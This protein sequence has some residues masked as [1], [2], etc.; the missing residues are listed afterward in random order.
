MESFKTFISESSDL[1]KSQVMVINA[2]K[3]DHDVE[4]EVL[5][6][7]GKFSLAYV[8]VKIKKD[9][10]NVGVSKGDWFT[11]T[12]GRRGKIEYKTISILRSL[13]KEQKQTIVSN[14]HNDLF[15]YTTKITFS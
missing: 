7:G 9:I 4:Y 1:T 11:L 15:G 2:F 3:K 5:G 13:D 10:K 14:I 6:G 12:V 8:T